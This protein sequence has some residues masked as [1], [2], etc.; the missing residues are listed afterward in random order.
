MKTFVKTFG[1]A[2]IIV[3]T[4]TA[5]YA[6]KFPVFGS[7]SLGPSIPV[8]DFSSK[9][10]DGGF[11]K[12]GTHLILQGGV[13]LNSSLGVSIMATAS[14]A[15]TEDP[16]FGGNAKYAYNA[17]LAGPI[18]SLHLSSRLRFELRALAG[19]SQLQVN[20]KCF[21]EA[22]GSG[23]GYDLGT[24]L[25]FFLTPV[26]TLSLTSDYFSSNISYKNDLGTRRI[27]TLNVTF[28]AGFYF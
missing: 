11:A 4:Y 16:Y 22:S 15:K 10:N 14:F 7:L 3:L 13:L 27:Q 24:G 17:I 25:R 6:Q 2:L 26:W 28:G 8:G 9:L 18:S 19:Y 12:V 5:G 21:M 20:E 1:A 23:F